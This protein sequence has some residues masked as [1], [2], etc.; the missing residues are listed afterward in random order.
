MAA[1]V[2]L[3]W[4]EGLST[5]LGLTKPR[6]FIASC[7]QLTQSRGSAPTALGLILSQLVAALG[8]ARHLLFIC[9]AFLA[10][11]LPSLTILFVRG[12]GATPAAC[13]ESLVYS[14]TT[15]TFLRL[16][17]NLVKPSLYTVSCFSTRP[18]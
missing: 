13:S 18:L 12:I 17:C 7:S 4:A 11:A 16:V 14:E 1:N 6:G 9:T 10:E 5:A 2:C 3:D 8:A 15:V